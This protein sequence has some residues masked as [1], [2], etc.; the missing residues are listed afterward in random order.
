MNTRGLASAGDSGSD[1]TKRDLSQTSSSSEDSPVSFD[2]ESFLL[3]VRFETPAE[4]EVI[5]I[6][7]ASTL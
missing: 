2:A 7:L 3:Q 1:A 4:F 5:P 6:L